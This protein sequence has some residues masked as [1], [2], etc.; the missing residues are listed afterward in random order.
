MSEFDIVFETLSSVFNL[1]AEWFS[2]PVKLVF[3]FLIPLVS[4]I[5]L[6]TIFMSYKL[7]IF[8]NDVVNFGIGCIIALLNSF[9]IRYSP[10]FMVAIGIGGSLMLSGQMTFW[11]ALGA[12][13][14]FLVTL[15]LYPHIIGLFV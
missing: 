5:A 11:R 15:F 1:P 9:L 7:K 10:P 6:W 14:L 3:Y 13:I 2:S 12:I 4:L 8:R